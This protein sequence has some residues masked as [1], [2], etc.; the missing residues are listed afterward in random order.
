M[1]YL[2]HV[3]NSNTPTYGNKD[4]CNIEKVKEISKGDK[5]NNSH[6]HISSHVGTHIDAPYHFCDDGRTI[7]EYP[8]EFWICKK[9]WVIDLIINKNELISY[10]SIQDQLNEIP[11]LTDILFFRTGFENY[12]NSSDIDKYIFYNP[13]ISSEIGYWLRENKCIKMIGLD[14]ISLS[15][16]AHRGEGRYAHQAFLCKYEIKDK[17]FD[18]ILIIEDMKLSNYSIE[19]SN[20]VISPLR[21]ENGDGSPVTVIAW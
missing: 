7:D 17:L 2:N 20:I 15:S 18:P 6:I 10:N 12:R 13:G 21:I 16:Y 3:L 14:F 1:I 11:E 8:P 5:S 19:L 4:L 9:P